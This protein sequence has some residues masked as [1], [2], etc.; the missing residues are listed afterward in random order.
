MKPECCG[1][2]FRREVP[3]A[4]FRAGF[5]CSRG[6]P[7]EH[8]LFQVLYRCPRCGSLLEVAHDLNAIRSRTAAEWKTLFDDRVGVTR[9][10]YG[11]GVWGKKEWVM[12]EV[13][14]ERVTSLFEGNSNLF[15]AERFGKELGLPD[16]W[17]KLCGNSHT[18]S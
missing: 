16:L 12:P 18:G 6:C 7:G 5:R 13:S 10:P 9:W 14:D 3:V 15:W 2:N 1:S 11:S 17:I 4:D 8:G